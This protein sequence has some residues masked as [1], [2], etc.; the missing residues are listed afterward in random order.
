M[1]FVAMAFVAVHRLAP[2]ASESVDAWEHVGNYFI[3]LSMILCALYFFIKESS[4]LQQ[5]PDGTFV[6]QPCACH[7]STAVPTADSRC[8]SSDAQRRGRRKARLCA[9]YGQAGEDGG[10]CAQSCPCPARSASGSED[11]CPSGSDEDCEG[12]PL[13]PKSSVK[14]DPSSRAQDGGMRNWCQQLF[15]TERGIK[16]AVLGVFQGACCPL[17]MVGISFLANLTIIGILGFLVIFMCVS[18]LGTASLAAAWAHLTARGLGSWIPPR[19]AYRAS[20]SFTL[21]LG[22]AWVMANYYQALGRLDYTEG[23][24]GHAELPHRHAHA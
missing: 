2:A 19:A 5:N 8:R 13:L 24:H 4:F 23:L 14:G 16:G 15:S 17:G 11:V 7:G 18:A 20:C 10:R 3:G 21:C 1:V 6:A 22:V 9:S 12:Q